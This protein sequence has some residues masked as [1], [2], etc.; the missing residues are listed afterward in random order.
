MKEVRV[1]VRLDKTLG[2]KVREEAGRDATTLSGVIRRIVAQHYGWKSPQ[3]S[4]G[5]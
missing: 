4:A 2:D 1:N 3:K 5:N